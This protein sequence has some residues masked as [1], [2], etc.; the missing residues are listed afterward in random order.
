MELK[1]TTEN[2]ILLSKYI[3]CIQICH[4]KRKD[5]DY[6]KEIILKVLFLSPCIRKIVSR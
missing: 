5:I 4:L 6:Y 1:E 3:T 2:H